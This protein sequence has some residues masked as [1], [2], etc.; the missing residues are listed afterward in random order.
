MSI[1]QSQS[2]RFTPPKSHRFLL[3]DA[4]RG[5]AALVVVGFHS[6]P[7]MWSIPPSNGMLAVDFFFCLSG[8]IVAFSYEQRLAESL[9]LKDFFIVRLIRLY[10]VYFL[11][12]LLGLVMSVMTTHVTRVGEQSA[13]NWLILA[14]FALFIVPVHVSSLKFQFAF[15]LDMAAWSLFFELVANVVFALLVKARV[16]RSSIFLLIGAASGAILAHSIYHGGT[17]DVGSKNTT[18]ALGYA[19]VFLSFSTGVLTYRLYCS[20]RMFQL[21]S[22]SHAICATLVILCLSVILLS[23][24]GFMRTEFVRLVA[25]IIC[26][27]TLV[28]LG[29]LAQIPERFS[30]KC[31]VLGELSY[32]LYL[33]HLP[34][35]GLLY[36]R[37]VL[38]FSSAHPRVA[39]FG[40]ILFVAALA[41]AAWWIG[42]RW[43]LPIRRYLMRCYAPAKVRIPVNPT[44]V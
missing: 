24:I 9:S 42:E 2:I 13:I 8:F 40:L 3:L 11:G 28:Y 31:V 37:H 23:P 25:V 33:L 6:P 5:L 44:S 16:A 15:P 26:F 14:G 34:L 29:A 12:S 18:M 21:S 39:V 7:Q 19:R 20:T 10:P 36:A 32:P 17:M 30:R 22:I 1:I 27:P 38:R 41:A 43:D 4:L 35:L